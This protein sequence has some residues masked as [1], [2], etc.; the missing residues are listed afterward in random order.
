MDVEKR[1]GAPIEVR[2]DDDA[3]VL[4]AGYAAVFDDW[5]PIG[6][7]FEE[8]IATGAF[9][10]R[11]EDDAVFLINHG[12]LPLARVAAGT[13]KLSVDDRGLF[14]ETELDPSDPDAARVIPKI[15]RG[16][17]SQMS[18]AFTV[19]REEWDDTGDI[20]R[21]K[22]LEIGQLIDVAVVNNGAYPNTEIGLRSL[23][24]HRAE[25]V[26]SGLAKAANLRRLRLRLSLAEA[27]GHT[28]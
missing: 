7:W 27:D 3:L 1:S 18:F 10:G 2:N 24:A 15:R 25:G 12:G 20:P 4:V 21:R 13:L 6:D 19:A 26:P 16:D 8:C 23:E 9:E 22:I 11:L 5:T 17:L 14:M 28:G